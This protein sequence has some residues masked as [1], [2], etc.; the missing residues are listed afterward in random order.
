MDFEEFKE[1]LHPEYGRSRDQVVTDKKWNVWFWLSIFTLYG[2]VLTWLVLVVGITQSE[3][4]VIGGI[5]AVLGGLTFRS[6]RKYRAV[7]REV[8]PEKEQ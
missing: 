4:V 3:G 1:R 7:H 5:W 6:W 8:Y 2:P